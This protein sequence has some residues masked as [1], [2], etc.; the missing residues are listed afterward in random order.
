M[1]LKESVMRDGFVARGGGDAVKFEIKHTLAKPVPSAANLREHWTTKAKRVKAQRDLVL[2]LLQGARMLLPGFRHFS[3]ETSLCRIR[4]V[5]ISTRPLD[6]DN[7]AYAFKAHRD[8][9]A[10]WFGCDDG[11]T[12]FWK[13]SYAQEKGLPGIRIEIGDE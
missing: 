3:E 12:S 10:E 6:D 8:A 2:V 4:F 7:L 11:D 13:W 5:R 1:K 9:V